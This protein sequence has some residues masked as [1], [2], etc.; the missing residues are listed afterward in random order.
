MRAT[1]RFD[2]V[3]RRAANR[4]A[5]T[6]GLGLMLCAP[7]STLAGDAD[8][9]APLDRSAIEA[10]I[11]ALEVST[12]LEDR[13]R[14]EALS[15]LRQA[16]AAEQEAAEQ[17]AAEQRYDALLEDGR[18]EIEAALERARDAEEAAAEPVD[19][20]DRDLSALQRRVERA[21]TE[22][23]TLSATL[24]AVRRSLDE[25][26]LQSTEIRE[27]ILAAETTRD[28]LSRE[29]DA[30]AAGPASD[31]TTLDATKLALR[32]RIDASR[33]RIA[34]LQKQ[35]LAQPIQEELLAA[36][37][38]AL[39]AEQQNAEFQLAELEDAL[40]QARRE[41]V[42]Q[43][44]AEAGIG[45]PE[46]AADHPA[47]ITLRDAN[48][49]TAER[50]TALNDL[51]AQMRAA[52]DEATERA[53]EI[54]NAFVQAQRRLE[55]AG[56]NE[57][58][59]RM[60]VA[61]RSRL[62]SSA[63]YRARVGRREDSV[64]DASLSALEFEEEID[65]LRDADAYRETLPGME[66]T[67]DALVLRT[68]TA[69]MDARSTLLESTLEANARYLDSLAEVS[70]AEESL[71][72]AAQEF[73]ALLSQ[74]LLWTRTRDGIGLDTLF[75]LPGEA[76]AFLDPYWWQRALRGVLLALLS[77]KGLLG[78]AVAGWLQYLRRR[79]VAAL[80]ATAQG[81]NKPSQDTFLQ[82]L[83]ALGL[84]VIVA[85]PIPLLLAVEGLAATRL[86]YADEA[87]L[88]L[89]R[90]V[91]S[92]APISFVLL[93]VR[94]A[95]MRE[96]VLEAHLRLD[97]ATLRRMQRALRPL[98]VTFVLPGL[99]LTVSAARRPGLD[100]GEVDRALTLVLLLGLGWFLHRLLEPDAGILNGLRKRSSVAAGATAGSRWAWVLLGP[101][102]VL[103]LAAATLGGYLFSAQEILA[104]L[105]QTLG[106]L[107]LL[108]FLRE[109]IGRWLLIAR[110]RIQL[111]QI[112]QRRE[113]AQ[114]QAREEGEELPD[115]PPPEVDV[116]SLDRDTRTLVSTLIVLAAAAGV[117]LIWSQ[118]LPALT[119]LE[120]VTLWRTSAGAEPGEGLRPVT[121]G[122]GLLA[123]LV[124]FLA[125]VGMRTV[126]SLLEIVLRQ[127]AGIAPGSRAAFATLSRYAIVVLGLFA[128]MDLLGAS[129]SRLQWLVAA[130]GV[131]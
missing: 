86:A 78:L 79:L 103:L 74:R 111:A 80:R 34:R 15:A 75:D 5:L 123:L 38:R 42:L 65:D 108:A 39:I 6:L 106:L 52:R 121:A 14:T 100:A 81:I 64:R 104:G 27:A 22:L 20:E 61:E 23:A 102:V 110:R 55:V 124:G 32:A 77:P 67:T 85:L 101:P 99:L 54:E 76:L 37:R 129:W 13:T 31:A 24:T 63:T 114:R 16:L 112:M 41:R 92:V 115:A 47:V 87:T 57:V 48:L 95:C 91:I 126:P 84:T 18:R 40:E 29:L 125:Y 36:R 62:P 2:T 12:E 70:F 119:I 28:T 122:D 21:K 43:A 98:W 53:E 116:T 131:G 56:G 127:Q 19:I 88:V 117:F 33:A 46:A 45:I 73:E 109:L 8:L 105:I 113:A 58:I 35:L 72:R 128:A 60:L 59:G 89:G 66:G 83:Q 30:A 93:L 9:A 51:A 44:I 3:Y 49:E 4:L 26:A 25:G 130:L 120:D 10:R 7:P 71:L 69:L 17:R 90:A 50:L 118:L 94:A 96:G 11:A 107:G 1:M 68:V 97:G 82:T